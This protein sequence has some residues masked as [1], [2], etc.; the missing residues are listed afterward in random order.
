LQY[1]APFAAA[2]SATAQVAPAPDLI[3]QPIVEVVLEQEG[4]PLIDP[5]IQDL[6]QTR[7]G[8][9]LSIR[10]VRETFDHLYNLGRFDDIRPMAEPVPGGVRVRYV[11][12]PAHPVD[13]LEFR[14]M[15]GLPEGEVRRIVTDRFGTAPAESRAPQAARTLQS[16]YR[17]RGFPAAT[18]THRV[19]TTHNPD[20]ATLIFDIAAGRRARIAEV[21]YRYGDPAEAAT[22]FELPAIK[23]GEPYDPEKVND[24]LQRWEDRMRGQGFYQAR[25]SVGA[26]MPDDAYLVVTVTR[27]PLVVLEFAG[28]PLPAKDRDR[29]VPLRTE[30]SADEDLLED[31]K[32]AIEQYLHER[33]HR[34]AAADYTRNDST[35]GQLKITFH[36]TNGPRYTVDAVRF[37]G[38]SAFSTPELEKIV[39]LKGG[40]VFIRSTLAAQAAAV[41]AAYRTRGFVRA[42]VAPVEGVLPGDGDSQD[43][44]LEITLNVDEGPRTTVRTVA[45]S[46]NTV[47]SEAQLRGIVPV[48]AGSPY[49]ATDVLE[50]RD[51]IALS[52]QNRGYMDVAVR[53]EVALAEK[54]TVADVTYTVTEGSQA[55]IEHI[56]VTGNDKT[57]TETIVNELEFKEGEP[58]GLTALA[59]SRTKLAQ[60][61]LFRRINIQQVPHRGEATQDVV[62]QVVEA[63]RTTLGYGVGVEGTLRARPTGPGGTAEDHLELAPRGSFE[64]G[65]RNLWGTNRSVNLFT[66]VSLRSTDILHEGETPSAENQLESNPG[67]NE[68]RVVGTFREPRLTQRSELLLTGIVEQ[69]I[70]TTFNF[71]R[72]IVRAEVGTRLTPTLSVTGRYSFERTKLFDEIFTADEG[73][74]IDKLFPQV[75]ISKVAGSFIRDSRDDLL[76]PGRG[77]FVIVDT[78]LAARALGSEVGFVRTFAQGFLYR[79]LPLQRRIVAAFG[80]RVGAAHGFERVKDGQVVSDLPASERFFAGGDSTV[81]G[82]SLDRLGNDDTI[83]R[84]TGFPLGGNGVVIL[85]GELRVRIAGALQGVGFID[86]GNVFPKATQL[87]LRDLRSAAGFGVRVDSPLGPVRLDL[88]FNLDPK[89]FVRASGTSRE[90]RMVFHISIGQA[91]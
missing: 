36:V 49:V 44:R 89:E 26:N 61:G 20:R 71:S 3:D 80:A 21:Q 72:R 81:R 50:G 41:E 6:I 42:K 78:D 13:R 5:L 64:I 8:R 14:G 77:T 47:I 17:T 24:V 37:T 4:K 46:G 15:L 33:G 30:G 54:D 12:I 43:R 7:V 59:N 56:I 57:K 82:F 29:L 22:K 39:T 28:D 68:F 55:I 10:D 74:L 69:A 38:N 1:T 25:A 88:G 52:Y 48:V 86:A 91:F 31:A 34:D 83:S 67:F 62:I 2:Q 35:S 60:L 63:D 18:V 40:D 90:K 65:R 73:Q 87:S 32:L 45:F 70:R 84:E 85:N 19:E 27:G 23:N 58:L 16:E 79:S 66:R 51:V 11:L 75:R 9:P 76:D 53:E